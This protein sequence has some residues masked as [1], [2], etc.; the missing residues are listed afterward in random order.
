MTPWEA[1]AEI[2]TGVGGN[3]TDLTELAITG[4]ERV[5]PSTY[6]VGAAAAAAV[7]V[8][9]LGAA[10]LWQLRGGPP[11]AASV[12]IR[13]A[14]IAYRSE[15]YLRV[16]GATAPM[17]ADISGDY[18]ASDGWVRIHA[19]YPNH[20]DAALRGLGGIPNRRE[21]VVT[22]VAKRSA[23]DVEDAVY[24]AGG[25]AAA[26]RTAREWAD[27]PQSTAV[28]RLPLI[29]YSAASEDFPPL[30]LSPTDSPLGTVRVL[31]L[32]RVIAGPVAGRTLAAYGAHVLRVG[33]DHLP[34][35]GPLV[36]DTGFGKRFCHLDLRTERGRQALREL[37]ARA[38]VL[39]QAYRPGA[40]Q[41]LGFGP[42]DCAQLRPGLVYVSIS[43]WGQAGPWRYRRGFDSL[44][45]M[46][47]GIAAERT[48]SPGADQRGDHRQGT[49]GP[50][51]GTFADA[52]DDRPHP[53]PA[54]VLDHATGW[55]A[56]FA[57]IEGLRRRHQLGGSWH[58]QLSLAR[59][60][61][62]LDSL[63]R[64]E[65]GPDIPEPRESDLAD[66]YST[67]DSPVGVLRYVRPPGRVNEYIPHWT[68]PPPSPGADPAIWW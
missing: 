50:R 14:T 6:R 47:T 9:T 55:L 5:L 17:W 32:T 31:D 58:A 26:M 43:A 18:E 68:T 57:A 60:A 35:V 48:G 42:E 23:V 39:I 46:A 25:A 22:A 24:A 30:P 59:T 11:A 56:A 37:I 1:A 33:A 27:H 63:G 61:G 8:T 45:Q 3:P 16:A 44:V 40:L 4:D 13:H 52:G 7:G 65:D 2:W 15:R 49:S 19:N 10:R 20:R 66:L 53:L 67:M 54:Q 38:D 12:D 28:A 21:E 36:F 62:W 41:R 29:A 64:L 51:A 34:L